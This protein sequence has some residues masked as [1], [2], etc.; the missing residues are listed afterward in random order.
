MLGPDLVWVNGFSP[1]IEVTVNGS[2]GATLEVFGKG[3]V[4]KTLTQVTRAGFA[5]ITYSGLSEVLAFGAL[6][7]GDHAFVHA[8]AHDLGGSHLTTGSVNTTAAK[9]TGGSLSRTAYAEQL[10]GTLAWRQDEAERIFYAYLRRGLDPSGRSYYAE[11]IRTGTKLNTIRA[12]VLGSS[13]YFRNRASNSNALYV[14]AVYFDVLHRLPDPSGRTY[15]LD[16]LNSGVPREELAT[17]ILNTDEPVREFIRYHFR[18]LLGRD[19][20]AS[21]IDAWR[22]VVRDQ[23]TGERTLQVSLVASAGYRTRQ[24]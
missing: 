14:D 21:E 16:R 5:P 10:V 11:K 20:S 15:W 23:A 1:T 8:A 6:A 24:S 4:V 17:K 19:P 18:D 12:T 2:T 22:T 3:P 13:E 9:I 7:S